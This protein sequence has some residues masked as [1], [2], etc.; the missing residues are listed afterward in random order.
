ML[1]RRNETPGSDDD[2]PSSP[3]SSHLYLRPW[4]GQSPSATPRPLVCNASATRRTSACISS[5]A[6]SAMG[7]PSSVLFLLTGLGRSV[8]LRIIR[9]CRGPREACP[10]GCICSAALQPRARSH[11]PYRAGIPRQW[12]RPSD[13]KRSADKKPP[14]ESRRTRRKAGRQ[15]R[16]L[17]AVA[18]DRDT[19]V[20]GGSRHWT[21]SLLI[22]PYW[23]YIRLYDMSDNRVVGLE[24]RSRGRGDS[25]AARPDALCRCRHNCS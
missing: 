8:V 23:R 13:P 11:R 6:L 7:R 25:A 18:H 24:Q 17:S 1:L 16:E 15:Q 20:F 5:R 22:T 19:G 9:R 2:R 14:V 12:P 4:I 21:R 10:A 3:T